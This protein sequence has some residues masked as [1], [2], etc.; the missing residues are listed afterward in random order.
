MGVYNRI[1]PA[2]PPPTTTEHLMTEPDPE[3][4]DANQLRPK[5]IRH[6]SLPPDLL[7]RVQAVYDAIGPYL[8]TTLEQ[9]QVGF[10]READP[11]SEVARWCG[12]TVAW[13]AYHEQYVGEELLPDEDEQKLV[14]AL[15][16]ISTGVTDLATLGVP[17]DVG[18]KLWECYDELGEE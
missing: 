12:I 17:V 4:V 16:A 18:R 6:Q 10:L 1:Q 5:P 14:G 8:D 2:H 15:I 11:A 3:D 13:V 7:E 9:F